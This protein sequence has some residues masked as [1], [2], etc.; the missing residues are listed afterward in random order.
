MVKPSS[1]TRQLRRP[2]R[3]EGWI[4]T[5]TGNG[6]FLIDPRPEDVRLEDIAYG[7]AYTYRYGG[8][9]APITVAEHSIIVSLI[10]FFVGNATYMLSVSS[11][12]GMAALASLLKHVLPN[13]YIM[14][15][16]TEVAAGLEVSAPYL[17]YGLAY[18]LAYAVAITALAVVLFKKKDI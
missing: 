12:K 15:I 11:G 14:D 1:I 5:H 18:G 13:F 7:L 10:I 2:P 6:F 16:K 9:V 3:W 17:L 8:Q 4:P